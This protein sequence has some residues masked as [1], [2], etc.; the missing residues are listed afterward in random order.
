MT[1]DYLHFYYIAHTLP[2][3]SIVNLL[4][5]LLICI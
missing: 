3:K 4:E 5:R 1:G 2:Y